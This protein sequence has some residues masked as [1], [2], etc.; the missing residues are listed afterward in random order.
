M[1]E[2]TV[3]RLYIA[4]IERRYDGARASVDVY[5]YDLRDAFRQAEAQLDK[6]QKLIG[7]RMYKGTGR[8]YV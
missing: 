2:G 7:V 5:A 4:R 8:N 6:G 1:T 3:R